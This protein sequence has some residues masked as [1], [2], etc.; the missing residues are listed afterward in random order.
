MAM[1]SSACK[2]DKFES[3]TF[4]ES[5]AP[6]VLALYETNLDGSIDS[7]NFSVRGFLFFNPKEF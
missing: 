1:L 3:H 4:L 2:P 5:N 7:G 6:D